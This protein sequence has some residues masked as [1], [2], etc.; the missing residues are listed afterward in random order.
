MNAP[1]CFPP[2]SDPLEPY[3]R[4]LGRLRAG[5][6]RYKARARQLRCRPKTANGEIRRAIPAGYAEF[7]AELKNRIQTAQ[8]RA[9]LAVNRELVL[10]CWE[11]GREILKKQRTDGW[12]TG[13]IERLARDLQAAFPGMKGLSPRN[14]G[15]EGFRGDLG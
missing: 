3:T 2:A 5:I 8:S 13:V 14:L 6:P 15:Y 12:G 9:S 1:P 4:C 7:L 10:L 11:I